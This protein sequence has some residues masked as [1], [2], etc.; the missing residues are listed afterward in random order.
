MDYKKI[1]KIET[2]G[3]DNII[4]QDINANNIVINKNNPA[5]LEQLVNKI[6]KEQLLQIQ[7]I[8]DQQSSKAN[9]LTAVIEK[10]LAGR[11]RKGKIQSAVIAVAAV[12]I[13]LISFLAYQNYMQEFSFKITLKSLSQNNIE[14]GMLIAKTTDRQ[15]ESEVN[16]SGEAYFNNIPPQYK[17]AGFEFELLHPLYHLTQ[18]KATIKANDNIELSVAYKN[19]Y[20]IYGQVKDENNQP[21]QGVKVSAAD[22]DATT[23]ESGK[24][25]ITIPDSKQNAE[26]RLTAFK[27]GYELW[28]YTITVDAQTETKIILIKQ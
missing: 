9:A 1:N 16:S 10:E 13:V 21:L 3:N 22:I 15:F 4:L 18:T 20:R 6:S 14:S 26:Q 28:D 2:D 5:E 12:L 23:N 24:F 17:K 7:Q 8:I 27:T 19:L 11:K 25:E